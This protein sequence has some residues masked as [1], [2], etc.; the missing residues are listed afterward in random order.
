M[1]SGRAIALDKMG[2]TS[3]GVFAVPQSVNGGFYEKADSAGF[4]LDRTDDCCC[5]Y[6]YL[7]GSRHS[8][9]PR[10]HG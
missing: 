4:Y 3:Q 2:S 10:L 8:G 6:R 1:I 5:D 9:I 7:G